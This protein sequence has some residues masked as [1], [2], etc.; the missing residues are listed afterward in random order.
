MLETPV[1]VV[2]LCQALVVVRHEGRKTGVD[3]SSERGACQPTSVARRRAAACQTSPADT[4][5][6]CSLNN[7]VQQLYYLQHLRSFAITSAGSCS[8]VVTCTMFYTVLS[9]VC[10][11]FLQLCVSML[12]VHVYLLKNRWIYRP[13]NLVILCHF[14][15]LFFLPAVILSTLRCYI[16]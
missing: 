7:R 10:Y 6:G 5:L 4:Y 1:Y 2:L 13:S 3:R 11:C 16:L 8:V 12:I 14:C 9:P 15:R